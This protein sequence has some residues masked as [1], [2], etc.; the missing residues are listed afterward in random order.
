MFTYWCTFAHE[1]RI[2]VR[3]LAAHYQSTEF[4]QTIANPDKK[5]RNKNWEPKT[6]EKQL[7]MIQ[8]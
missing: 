5:P 8:M 6:S 3:L 7:I 1:N 4:H 2:L